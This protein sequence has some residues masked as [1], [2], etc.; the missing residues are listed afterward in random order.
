MCT[1]SRPSRK[2]TPHL[3]T[4]PQAA[5]SSGS[6]KVEIFVISSGKM[7]GIR[8]R[9]KGLGGKAVGSVGGF[10]DDFK[11]F[12]DRGNV[13]DLAVGVILGAAFGAV[14]AS[15]VADIFSP[16][17][18]LLGTASLQD[19]FWVMRYPAG[20]SGNDTYPTVVKA[21]EAGAI[22][23]NYGNFV[24]TVINFIMVAFCLFIF[25]KLLFLFKK[26]AAAA[27]PST[28]WPCPK[29]REKVKEGAIRCPHCT[30]E[31]I[32]QPS[33]VLNEDAGEREHLTAKA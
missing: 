3:L 16:V 27:A 11:K 12:I 4:A 23:M 10:F 29:C 21:K 7:A 33:V 25:I 28:D 19:L 32:F 2:V 9:T 1:N 17:L 13:V 14:V 6:E 30:A 20:S 5:Y 31:P 22:T 8:E 26:K 18:G 24:Q 15:L